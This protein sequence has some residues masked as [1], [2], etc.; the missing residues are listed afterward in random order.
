VAKP[1]GMK[2]VDYFL[3]GVTTAA[4]IALVEP[5]KSTR[6]YLFIMNN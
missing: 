3:R 6:L 1:N 4:F 2:A 5:R